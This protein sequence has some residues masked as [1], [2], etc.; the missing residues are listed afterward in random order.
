MALASFLGG[1][2]APFYVS[3]LMGLLLVGVCCWW[4]FSRTRNATLALAAGGAVAFH[5]LVFT[6]AIQP[7]S[8]VPAAACFLL[9]LA[10]LTTGRSGLL[11]GVAA[12][13]AFLIRPALLPGAAALAIVPPLSNRG[14]IPSVVVFLTTVACGFALQLWS[15]WYLYG[16]PLANGYGPAHELFSLAFLPAN[17]ESYSN[18]F[19]RIHRPL[20]LLGLFIACWKIGTIRQRASLASPLLAAAAPYIVYR[21]YDHWETLRFVLPLLVGATV[22]AVGGFFVLVRR[23][24][25]R[26]GPWLALALVV[27]LVVDWTG[28]LSREQVFGR[29]VSEERFARAGDLVTRATPADAVVLASLHS[30]SLRY[31]SQRHTLD[32]EKI[33]VGQFDAT[34][35]A[36]QQHGRAVFVMIDGEEEHTAF[37]ARHGSV[38]DRQRWLPA[39]QVRDIRMYEAPR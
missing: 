31:Y 18:W 5:P 30:G 12:S 34:V 15:Q 6:Y 35:A 23:A 4:T 26:A 19:F 29:W 14:R 22:A 24:G 2:R 13:A 7:M 27:V 17:V 37:V 10:L 36:L 16:D 11:A 38:L 3:P 20:F 25:P 33:P 9:A 39:G 1:P 32:W 8:D 21:T 28:W